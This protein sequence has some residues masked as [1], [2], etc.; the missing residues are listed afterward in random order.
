VIPL[1]LLIRGGIGFINGLFI[2]KFN[3]PSFMATLSV[4]VVVEGIVLVGVIIITWIQAGMLMLTI[5]H[6]I[7]MIIFRL[8]TLGRSIAMID[9]RRIKVIK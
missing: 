7:Q 3:V 1:A 5:G 9:R 8:I 4:S 2:A 6:D